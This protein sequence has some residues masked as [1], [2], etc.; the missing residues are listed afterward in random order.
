MSTACASAFTTL[1]TN[2][3]GTLKANVAFLDQW[4]NA[5][6][7]LSNFTSIDLTSTTGASVAPTSL[8]VP[9]GST[10]T[11]QF[12]VTHSSGTPTITVNPVDGNVLATLTFTVR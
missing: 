8:D 11:A 1:G 5:A 6:A 3:T 12:T 2:G 10:Q 4:G 7:A 9:L